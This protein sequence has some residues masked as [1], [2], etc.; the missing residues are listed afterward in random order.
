MDW[1]EVMVVKRIFIFLA[2][3]C[4]ATQSL[5]AMDYKSRS[6]GSLRHRVSA[7]PEVAKKPA[8]WPSSVDSSWHFDPACPIPEP[9]K[10]VDDAQDKKDPKDVWGI[11]RSWKDE[12]TF[13]VAREKARA[14]QLAF[15]KKSKMIRGSSKRQH[16]DQRTSPLSECYGLLARLFNIVSDER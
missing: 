12:E 15:N 6:E 4:F 13:Q 8:S 10:M 5:M 1:C 2:V 14:E 16:D 9:R 11:P 7:L 3:L